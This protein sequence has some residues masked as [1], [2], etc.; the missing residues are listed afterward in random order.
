MSK[1]TARPDAASGCYQLPEEAHLAL[2][3]TRDRLHL[4]ARL[5]APRSTQDDL[6]GAELPLKPAA[7]AHCFQELAERL[8]HSLAEAR[9]PE[10]PKT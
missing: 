1:G 7:L 8:D 5:A 2:A 10:P 6:P 4:L 9:W 3:Q